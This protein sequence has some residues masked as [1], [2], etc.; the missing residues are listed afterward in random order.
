M[1]SVIRGWLCSPAVSHNP[2]SGFGPL[3]L[4]L[5]LTLSWQSAQA[6]LL[7]EVVGNAEPKFL[8]VDQAFP[9]TVEEDGNRLNVRFDTADG[10]YLYKSRLYLKQ[11]KEKLYP[12]VYSQQGKEKQ[13]DAFG[14][15][16]AFYND[17]SVSFDLAELQ[18]GP[19]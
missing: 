7:D 19:Y 9:L 12:D 16:T 2:R 8:P 10:Y 3:L 18:R 17:L 1:I 11:G 15:V 6:S 4:S 13:D 5:L 14:L